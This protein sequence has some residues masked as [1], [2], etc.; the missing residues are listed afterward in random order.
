MV[1]DDLE[2]DIRAAQRA[3]LRGAFVLTGKHTRADVEAAAKR[4][5]PAPDLVAESL[6]DVVAALD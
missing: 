5:R 6:A 2:T 4:G 1:G 3:G